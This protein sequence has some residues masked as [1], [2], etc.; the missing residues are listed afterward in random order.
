MLTDRRRLERVSIQQTRNFKQKDHRF[1]T[2]KKVQL[3]KT[4]EVELISW[5]DFKEKYPKHKQNK[6]TRR[7]TSKRKLKK[8]SS[9]RNSKNC[10]TRSHNA[11]SSKASRRSLSR[12]KE[13]NKSY[14]LV[15]DLTGKCLKSIL[16]VSKQE[17]SS[18]IYKMKKSKDPH[19]KSKPKN[20]KKYSTKYDEK[21]K[22]LEKMYQE[23]QDLS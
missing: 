11:A 7:S 16:D 2:L 5:S 17:Q 10:S 1:G 15:K 6:S 21:L 3:R 9:N 22:K 23:L 13:I 8:S 20:Q 12:E 14:E 18:N 4:L 19:Q